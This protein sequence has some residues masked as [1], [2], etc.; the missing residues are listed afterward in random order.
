[1]SDSRAARRRREKAQRK[2]EE[3]SARTR[4]Q[5]HCGDC[6]A[7]CT[8]LKVDE[9]GKPAYTTC[10]AQ[11]EGGCGLYGR[12]PPACATFE[13]LWFQGLWGDTVRPD[14]FGL[15]FSMVPA[16][17]L[18]AH[19]TGWADDAPI[20]W[21]VEPGASDEPGPRAMLAALSDHS[22]VFVAKADGTRRIVAREKRYQQEG[23]ATHEEMSS[24]GD[25]PGKDEAS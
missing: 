25:A 10:E 4:E 1:M 23:N 7:C 9:I 15:M 16:S 24:G 20:A 18:L 8:I 3:R 2:T 6:Q 5:R 22:P 14:R 21:E 17:K 11:C 13:C 12:R 19:L